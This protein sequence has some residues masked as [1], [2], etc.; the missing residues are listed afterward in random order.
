MM[1]SVI[2]PTIAEMKKI[3][4]RFVIPSHCTGWGAI[5]RFAR[6]MPEQFILNTVGTRYVIA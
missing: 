1:E 3:H 5:N 4:P 2:D 6:E